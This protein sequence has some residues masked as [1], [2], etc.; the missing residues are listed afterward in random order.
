MF[1][2]KHLFMN[3]MIAVSREINWRHQKQLRRLKQLTRNENL[4]KEDGKRGKLLF[5]LFLKP[6]LRNDERQTT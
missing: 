6:Q 4:I 1:A 5:C 3:P 2:A